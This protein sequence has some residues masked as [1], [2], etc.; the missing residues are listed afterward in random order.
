MGGSAYQAHDL[1]WV[2]PDAVEFDGPAPDWA[3]AAWL[4]T[5][6]VVVRRET[7]ADRR[8]P[9]GVRGLA[10]NQ[11]SR[12]YVRTDA[13]MRRVTPEM[14]CGAAGN[15]PA[16]IAAAMAR[17]DAVLRDGALGWGPTGGVGFFL[18]SALPVLRD[19]SDLDLV[20]RAPVPLTGAQCATLAQ[21]LAS[22]ACRLDVQI[23]TGHGAFS[24]MEWQRGSGVLLK[25]C[26][27][28]LLCSDPWRPA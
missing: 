13:V 12:A 16:A 6:P 26:A 9:V 19:D 1:L 14:L 23:D 21:L 15:A 4:R 7:V 22:P 24:L 20:I 18:A 3:G 25:T 27:G 10:R 11:R 2:D 5:A 17:A 28:P 8:I